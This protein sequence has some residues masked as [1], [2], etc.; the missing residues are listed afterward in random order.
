MSQPASTPAPQPM[1]ATVW[2]ICI[3]AAI[4]GMATPNSDEVNQ[5]LQARYHIRRRR[6]SQDAISYA[7]TT[8]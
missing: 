5:E 6:Q 4:G 1:T 7:A 2:L 8:E 3:I